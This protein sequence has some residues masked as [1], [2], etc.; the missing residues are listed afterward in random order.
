MNRIACFLLLALPLVAAADEPDPAKVAEAAEGLRSPD[1]DT[2]DDA[3]ALVKALP[4]VPPELVE[5]L[6]AYLRAETVQGFVT[7]PPFKEMGPPPK[8]TPVSAGDVSLTRIKV[9]S[10]AY[11]DKTFTMTGAVSNDTYYNRG[12]DDAAKTH[13]S[14]RFVQLN[15]EGT[16][17]A[18]NDT[19][20]VYLKRSAGPVFSER[21]TRVEEKGFSGA[22]VRLRCTIRAE[23]VRGHAE[24]ALEHIEVLDWQYPRRGIAGWTPWTTAGLLEDFSQLARAG[25]PAVPA[26]ARMVSS[27]NAAGTEYADDLFRGGAVLALAQ[28][29]PGDRKDARPAIL[30]AARAAR[31]PAARE[32]SQ[33]ALAAVTEAG[34]T[35]SAREAA[36]PKAPPKPVN[37]AARAATTLK[38]GQNLERDGKYDGAIAYYRQVVKEYPGTPQAKVAAERINALGGR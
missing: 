34:D 3:I 28:L 31:T 24:D 35:P 38:A 5:P 30:Q 21:I 4:A 10:E 25:A 23:R 16:A 29:K 22:L 8:K 17:Q 2:R 9:N 14:F 32:W 33:R 11:T 6:V 26:L 18:G 15:E 12:Y 7:A 36:K 37:P 19:A 1:G 27:D 20:Y 13:Y